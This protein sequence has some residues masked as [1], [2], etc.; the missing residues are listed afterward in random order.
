[1]TDG[2]ENDGKGNM[3]KN[4]MK[5]LK[6]LIE[7]KKKELKIEVTLNCIGFTKDNDTPFLNK[8]A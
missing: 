3:S 5:N 2:V 4:E 1:M 6:N 7:K 8:L